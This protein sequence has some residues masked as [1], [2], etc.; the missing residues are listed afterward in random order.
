MTM[1]Q[2][3][4]SPVLD[5][6]R[7][8]KYFPVGGGL[9]TQQLRALHDA[10]F[11]LAEREVIALV[12]ESGS[13]KSTIARLLARLMPPSSGQILFKGR[14]VLKEE[15]NRASLAYRGQVQ[16]I[17]Q[18][19]FGSLNPVHTIGYHLERPLLLHNKAPNAAILREKV[20]ALLKTVDLNPPAE[21][22]AKYPYQL[23]GGQR[24]RVAIARALA[25]DPSVILA[26]E[27]I[28][29]L[30]VSIRMGVLNLMER[31][32]EERGI[33][34]LY[35]T[36]DIASA[37]YVADRTMVMY[38]GHIVEGAPSEELMQQP[39]H[40]YTKLLLSAV[41]DPNGSIRS[42]LPAR[43]GAPKLINPPPGCPFADRC[44]SV[45]NTCREAM[46]A[47]VDVGSGHWVRCHLYSPGSVAPSAHYDRKVPASVE[48]VPV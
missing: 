3:Y 35:I 42:E 7:L 34:Y 8:A 22:A 33:S 38:A 46:P 20:H 1:T 18:D 17:F 45:M 28:S 29:M 14:D 11:S 25:V 16:M 15:P 26:D 21:A 12:G 48:A 23:S 31:L 41:P 43:S 2:P 37:R 40:P 27:P 36:H 10:S 19:P 47:A 39:A 32:K 9:R 30:D 5:V 24:Q 6:V 4:V 13:G 44:P